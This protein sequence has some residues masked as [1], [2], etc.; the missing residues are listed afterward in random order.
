M[1]VGHQVEA[2]A[3]STFA[4]LI[5]HGGV[6]TRIVNE[7][8]RTNAAMPSATGAD[9]RAKVLADLDIIFN[10][11]IEP[12][13]KNILNLLLELGV[14]YTYAQSPVLG[15]VAQQVASAVEDKIK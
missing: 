14:A 15:Q 8:E 3:I 9:K 2:V 6:F 12:I 11:L 5:G 4:E 13:A 10:D 1:S 7:I